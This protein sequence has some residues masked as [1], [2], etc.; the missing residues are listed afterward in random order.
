MAM[1]F[2]A[3]WFC[4]Q[5]SGSGKS[6]RSIQAVHPTTPLGEVGHLEVPVRRVTT[7]DSPE[8]GI[9]TSAGATVVRGEF[10]SVQVNV[11][12]DGNNVLGDAANEP[13][14]AIDPTNPSRMAIGWRQFDTI[15]SSFRQSGI[16]YS[17]DAG[18]SWTSPGATSTRLGVLEPGVFS[19]DPVLDFDAEGTFYYYALQPD[20]G[21]G[22]WACYSY[23]STDGGMT[24]PTEV[25]AWGGDKA[26]MTI[27]RT[28]GM[29]HGNLYFA[30]SP[31]AGCCGSDLFTRST[32]G[33]LSF[34]N[35]I[36][37]PESPR[38]GTLT[39]DPEGNLFIVGVV[40][41]G[42]AVVRSSNAQD[43]SVVPSFDQVTFADLGG[44]TS[45][46]PGP[47]PAGLLGQT[48]IASDH[49]N[50]TS[51]GNLYVLSSVD[52]PGND[53]LDVMFS[54]STDG[55]LTWSA[56]VRVNDD[57]P[58][59]N[60]WQWFGTMSVAPNGRIDVIWNDTRTSG[61]ESWSELYYSSSLDEG[62][63]WSPNQ[64]VS[65][66]FNSFLGWPQ[67]NKIGDY[68]DMISD[69]FGAN[70]AYAATFNDE[71]D[72]YYLRIGDL[73]CN[74]NGVPDVDDLAEGTSLDCNENQLPDECDR[75]CNG[76][77]QVDF[78]ETRD[79][80][81]EDCDGNRV[82]DTCDP[83]FDGDLAIDGCDDDID[84][85]GVANA[86]DECDFTA[87]GLPVKSDGRA[88]GDFSP[89]TDVTCQ[90]DLFD[91][92]IFYNLCFVNSGPSQL[93]SPLCTEPF[94]IDDDGDIDLIDF[95]SFQR[96]FGR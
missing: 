17:V 35:P 74:D 66:M 58:L 59:T 36:S 90:V 73:D 71:H 89:T 53:P 3:L 28:G 67:Q 15:A 7:Q 8:G 1:V 18:G 75:D 88:I 68:Y 95:A 32:N 86:A 21:P 60:A 77:D 19:S 54:R 44:N 39:V 20:R 70:V 92:N 76:N 49:S 83:D 40:G 85:D 72:V 34:L 93:I 6:P 38:W 82:P 79:G 78:C 45:S 9:A 56:A 23:R 42:F 22:S 81:T 84:N 91:F 10:V 57:G 13:S 5:A 80:L 41:G 50:G 51:R 4:I 24:W 65:P 33:G 16:A 96:A 31:F 43:A 27:D 55:G 25:Y 14:I 69:A 12:P 62:R 61:L 30:W 47:N 46:E 63:T 52:P 37:I 48:W 87:L 2:A 11:N 94:S 26:W 29:G 64:P